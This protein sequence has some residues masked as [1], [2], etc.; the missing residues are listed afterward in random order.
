M[1]ESPITSLQRVLEEEWKKIIN[2]PIKNLTI[3]PDPHNKL[4]WHLKLKGL[5]EP[6]NGE[7]QLVL[8]FSQLFPHEAPLI[9]I[10]T[11]N[12]RFNTGVPIAVIPTEEWLGHCSI[13]ELLG[14]FLSYMEGGAPD[15]IRGAMRTDSNTLAVLAQQS[16]TVSQQAMT[17][18]HPYSA[19]LENIDDNESIMYGINEYLT[20]VIPSLCDV[21]FVVIPKIK[22]LNDGEVKQK[23]GL[24]VVRLDI[25]MS[26]WKYLKGDSWP[27]QT[28]ENLKKVVGNFLVAFLDKL[29]DYGHSLGQRFMFVNINLSNTEASMRSVFSGT[30]AGRPV[31]REIEVEKLNLTKTNTSPQALGLLFRL[32]NLR[33]LYLDYCE[34]IISKGRTAF[35]LLSKDDPVPK[36]ELL[37]V[38]GTSSELSSKWLSDIQAA[39]PLLS[40]VYFTRKK[41][42]KTIG[43]QDIVLMQTMRIPSLLPCGHIGDK[44]SLKQL[45]YCSFDRQPFRHHELLELN[46]KISFLSK[47]PKNDSNWNA[48]IVDLQRNLLDAKV[49]YHS[50]CGNFFN[51]SSIK[52]LFHI[53]ATSLSDSLLHELKGKK[54]PDCSKSLSSLRVCYPHSAEQDPEDQ[55]FRDLSSFGAYSMVTRHND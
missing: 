25:D 6:C 50:D 33:E 24:P 28:G 20:E 9:E 36:L 19:A 51:L 4:V 23:D 2:S 22:V 35:S 3:N 16:I 48:A 45:G 46:P 14:K 52:T 38:I 44:E 37:S 42:T 53:E 15:N 17:A 43:W 12:G 8:H 1:E 40:K 34:Q 5:V 31:H 30:C 11:P 18:L 10:Q 55:K 21:G 39:C 13:R 7:Y 54:C 26:N 47:D 29:M 27:G 32:R 41:G 49:Y